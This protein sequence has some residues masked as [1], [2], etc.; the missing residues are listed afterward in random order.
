MQDKGDGGEG[1]ARSWIEQEADNRSGIKDGGNQR[2]RVAQV[3]RFQ[4]KLVLRRVAKRLTP[5]LQVGFAFKRGVSIIE[6]CGEG[7]DIL[8]LVGGAEI[9]P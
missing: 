8:F 2:E 1:D 9:I 4:G 7:I 3:E 5:C 6:E